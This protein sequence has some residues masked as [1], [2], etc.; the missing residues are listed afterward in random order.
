MVTTDRNHYEMLTGV[1]RVDADKV[2]E[3]VSPATE[4]TVAT[5]AR[6]SVEHADRAVEAARRAHEKG[7][8]RRKSPEERATVIKAMA[9][10]MR[11]RLD[12]FAKLEALENGAPIRQ[13]TAFHIGYSIAHLDYIGQVALRYPVTPAG[14]QLVYP[15]LADGTIRR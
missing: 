15:T 14:P 6:G 8:W 9:A 10:R 12:E 2:L 7:E 1:E 13:A 3:I 11:D 4:E 5:V